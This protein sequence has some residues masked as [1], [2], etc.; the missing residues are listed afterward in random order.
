MLFSSNEGDGNND[1]VSISRITIHG[2]SVAWTCLTGKKITYLII[3]D[4]HSRFIEVAKPN[5][6]TTEEIIRHCKSM[7]ARH[8]ISEV[9]ILDNGPPFD[10][11]IFRKFSRD[12]QFNHTT[13]SPYY[14]RGNGEAEGAVKTTNELWRTVHCK[15]DHVISTR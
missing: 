11:G 7:F 12:Y 14:P 2:K 8:G 6:L 3:V 13:S 1:N 10:Y 4:Y 5:R 9:V 15:N